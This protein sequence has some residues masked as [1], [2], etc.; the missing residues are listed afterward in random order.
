[1]GSSVSSERAFSGAGI[2]ISKHWNWL[3][4]D[5]VEALEYLKCMYLKDLIYRDPAPTSVLV[6]DELEVLDDD[7]DPDWED[8]QEM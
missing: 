7:G 4:A 6:E 8:E 3:K 2:T 5:I 1:M